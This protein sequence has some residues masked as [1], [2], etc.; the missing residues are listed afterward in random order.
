MQINDDHIKEVMGKV[1]EINP[2]ISVID[3]DN[4]ELTDKGA[5]DL[6]YSLHDFHQLTTPH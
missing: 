4:N 2:A 5:I 1:K 6:A 3:L